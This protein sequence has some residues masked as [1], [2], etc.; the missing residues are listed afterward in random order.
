MSTASLKGF[1]PAL[2]GIVGMTP[3]ALYERQRALV[4]AGLLDAEAGRGP[5][6]GVRITAAAVATLVIALM[7]GE[8]LSD[9]ARSTAAL[10]KAE[11]VNGRC[12]ITG[13]VYF[14][15]ALTQIFKDRLLSSQVAQVSVSRTQTFARIRPV[16][17][18]VVSEF[19]GEADWKRSALPEWAAAVPSLPAAIR[20]EATIEQK[21]IRAIADQVGSVLGQS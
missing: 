1:V 19:G 18:K 14:G 11:S 9:V 15:D 6:S 2:A 17:G 10:I 3:A 4:R 13:V 5:G 21:A 8:S 7:A 20:L 16:K 12:P